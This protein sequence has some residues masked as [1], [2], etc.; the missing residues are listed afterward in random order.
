MRQWWRLH[1]PAHHGAVVA[2]WFE[3][4]ILL[5]RHSYREG[6]G[7]PGG[8]VKSRENPAQAAARELLEELRLQVTAEDLQSAGRFVHEGDYRRDTADVYEFRPKIEPK[9]IIDNR[10]IIWAGFMTLEEALEVALCAQSRN[11]LSQLSGPP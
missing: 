9:I 5:V 6:Y 2:I 7:L 8:G 10:E 4:K 1:R 11:Y 3:R